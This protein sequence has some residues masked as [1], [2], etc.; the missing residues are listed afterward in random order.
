M[1][2]RAVSVPLVDQLCSPKATLKSS[3]MKA[4]RKNRGEGIPPDRRLDLIE[5]S[6]AYTLILLVLWTELP[7]QR[8]LYILTAISIVATSWR[9]FRSWRELGLSGRNLLRSLWIVAAALISAAII[10][11]VASKLDTLHA[12]HSLAAFVR[13]YWGYAVFA[14]VQ[15]FLLQ[16]FFLVRFLN[17]LRGRQAAAVLW[18][19]GIFA[20]AHVPNPIL[21]PLTFAWGLVACLLFLRYRNLLPLWI[22]HAILGVTVAVAIPGP[23]IHN[24]RVGL[25]Y[26]T[27]HRHHRS[28]A[29]HIVS[30]HACVMAEAPTLRC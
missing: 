27:Y 23:V 24:M 26:L 7:W 4:L 13:R 10:L 1:D 20:L 6:V 18:T 30:T 5:I 22:A 17:L 16:S 28:H 9:R 14:F 3:A 15:Q 8:P 12:P 11:A 25:G 29:D 19:A 21:T 2:V